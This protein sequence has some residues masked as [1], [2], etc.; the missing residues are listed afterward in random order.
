[1]SG[2]RPIVERDTAARGHNPFNLLAADVATGQWWWADDQATDPQPLGPGLYGLS[3]AA[4]DT[5]WPKVQRLKRALADA[6]AAAASPAALETMLFAALADR[7]AAPDDA[8]PDTGV[9]RER[10]RWL[11][12][13]FIRTPDLGYGTR[14]ST[15][16]IAE[17]HASGLRARIVER[18]F[19]D[20]AGRACA[21]R[22]VQLEHWPLPPGELPC[23][24]AEPIS[25]A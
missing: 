10:E 1:L 18:Q 14:C 22:S 5:P 21:Q 20:D 19:D 4:L 7:V 15:L 12:P 8:L 17:R 13:A 16:L 23:I 24:E 3:N 25:A 9:G 2:P 6:L 11:A